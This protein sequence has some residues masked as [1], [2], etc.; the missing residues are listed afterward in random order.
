MVNCGLSLLIEPN[1]ITALPISLS[2]LATKVLTAFASLKLICLISKLTPSVFWNSERKLRCN[3]PA[4]S[5][6]IASICFRSALFSSCKST[7]RCAVFLGFL[8]ISRIAFSSVCSV[9]KKSK[10]ALLVSA[11]MRRTPW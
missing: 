3:T 11:S 10:A 6:Y 5:K 7:T 2:K 9:F 8:K 4:C 1:M